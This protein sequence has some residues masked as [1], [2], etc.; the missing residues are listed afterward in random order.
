[1]TIA[2]REIAGLRGRAIWIV[3]AVLVAVT[4]AIVLY[5]RDFGSRS[6][7]VPQ[8]HSVPAPM[9]NAERGSPAHEEGRRP[10]AEVD[11]A[12][13][14]PIEPGPPH[15]ADAAP[16][17]RTRITGRVLDEAG[18]PIGAALVEAHEFSRAR[19]SR[20]RPS[21]QVHT[22]VD[23]RFVLV[24]TE[25]TAL[26]VQAVADPYAVT[27][28]APVFGGEE[29]SLV[30][31]PVARIDVRVTLLDGAPA[32]G[33]RVRV[34]NRDGERA[35]AWR[36]EIETDA[37]G[38]GV[39][40]GA[41]RA[42]L[43]LSASAPPQA[44]D[45]T[46]VDTSEVTEVLVELVLR[47]G[48]RLHGS[49]LDDVAGIGLAGARVGC[50]ALGHVVTD[51]AGRYELTGI[52]ASPN[53]WGIG[54]LAGGRE[55]VWRYVRIDDESGDVLLDFRLAPAPKLVGRVVD[56]RG[57][58]ILG[59]S[60]EALARVPTAAF[61]GEVCES[62]AETDAAG[63]FEIEPVHRASRIE[64]R[65]ETPAGGGARL[66]VGPFPDAPPTIEI[67]DVRTDSVGGVQGSVACA[68]VP[69]RR[70][71]RVLLR[72]A[73]A[74]G[75]SRAAATA[76]L[77]PWCGFRFE[78]VPPG[79]YWVELHA[80]SSNDAGLP[81]AMREVE[82]VPG[83]IADARLDVSSA[84]I[85][86]LV[87]GADD[88]SLR[89]SAVRL[90]V[91]DGSG[92]TVAH[93]GVGKTGEFRLGVPGDGEHVIDLVDPALRHERERVERVRPGE[94]LRIRLRPRLG[95]GRVEGL[96][97]AA[98]GSSIADLNVAFRNAS[99]LEAVGR[100]AIPDGG[101]RF[102]MEGLEDAPYLV[103]IVDFEGRFE[104]GPAL[105]VRPGG[106]TLDIVLQP[107]L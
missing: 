23:G 10:A 2:A 70:S 68:G 12:V 43:S 89:N 3:P 20:A 31:R 55:P 79:R 85:H 4:I 57:V 94:S 72:P 90:V 69:D 59:A 14:V 26:R 81:L 65:V 71:A 62:R 9:V 45:S 107:R 22:D 28:R 46:I 87:V 95:G 34:A 39:F 48:L 40:Q 105:V 61:T 52:G 7:E 11:G 27:W 98:D 44:S 35:A 18:A 54:A 83:A 24:V 19:S 51:A 25:R 93:G 80:S 5:Q 38:R 29:I 17:D 78:V 66:T 47:R 91:R 58:G 101:G 37:A 99:T 16:G 102:V 88:R 6:D 76:A 42:R 60:V 50:D 84:W 82:V 74:S 73:S 64:L 77:D 32:S 36:A 21:P 67:G 49:V 1:M 106:T 8:P 96:L 103:Q 104:P 33:A 63:I 97:R 13:V 100:V 41:P 75:T 86:G 30:L 15:G 56:A 92:R 53:A